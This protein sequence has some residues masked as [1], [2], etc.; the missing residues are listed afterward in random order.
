M[1]ATPRPYTV[2]ALGSPITILRDGA[3]Q[4]NLQSDEIGSRLATL[5]NDAY[6]AGVKTNEPHPE[7]P[8][9]ISY[10]RSMVNIIKGEYP[11]DHPA[12]VKA[13]KALELINRLF[14]QTAPTVVP[15]S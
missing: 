9:L 8:T 7:L 6:Q 11:D 2:V 3:F 4:V 1:S 5:L 15:T 10:A 12:Y 13:L 14:P